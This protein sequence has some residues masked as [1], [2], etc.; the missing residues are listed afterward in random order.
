MKMT[1]WKI[2]HVR[3][4]SSYERIR[5]IGEGRRS[6]WP[7]IGGGIWCLSIEPSMAVISLLGLP[8]PRATYIIRVMTRGAINPARIAR[9]AFAPSIVNLPGLKLLARFDP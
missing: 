4:S 2:T 6:G 8:I 7:P 9:E 1:L 3:L 5:A